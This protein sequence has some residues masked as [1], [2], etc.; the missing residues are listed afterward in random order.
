MGRDPSKLI[1]F[2]LADR[3]VADSYRVSRPFP[4]SERFGVQLQVRRAAVSAATNIVEGCARKTTAEYLNF[5]NIAAGSAAEAGYLFDL[6][7]R[8][9]FAHPPEAERL[10]TSYR[11]LVAGLHGLIR[12]LDQLC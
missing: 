6:A 12:S 2:Q 1:L 10:A 5:L 4:A 3:L 11:E 8:L 9:G 7:G